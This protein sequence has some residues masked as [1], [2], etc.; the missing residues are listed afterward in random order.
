MLAAVLCQ[1]GRVQRLEDLGCA[2][3]LLASAGGESLFNCVFGRDA[4][5]MALDLP[6]DFP[7]VARSTLLELARLQG[8]V[9]NPRADEQ[10]G[11][12]LH[13]HRYAHDARA[14]ELGA[15]WDFPYY[16]AVDSTPQWIILLGACCNRY[17]D[18]ILREPLVDRLGR[19]ITLRD[20]LQ[21]ALAWLL[22]RLDD[23]H[24]YGF[25]WVKRSSP[26]GMLNQVWEDSF[27]AYHHAD[28]RLLD[29]EVPYAPVAP[30]GYT[31]DA[32]LAAA[33]LLDRS[34]GAPLAVDTDALRLR[35]ARLREKVLSDFWL[36]DLG[37]FAHALE[38]QPDGPIPARVVASSPGHLLANRLLDGADAA[39]MRDSLAATLRSDAMLAA[40]G[41]RTKSTGSPRFRAGA[42]HNGSTWPMDTG[43]IADGLRRHG[44]VAQADDL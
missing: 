3:P 41:V 33:T 9:E 44:Y 38:L 29:P 8:V 37:A 20:S 43:V 11:R 42:Y 39:P 6:E 18:T 36:A 34:P 30:Q 19:R 7:L 5:R 16:G 17:G 32:L 1:L 25:L 31:Y 28:G 22:T 23:P 27:D 2:G 40:A 14:A 21:A 10:P 35:A 24:G 13:E 12:I 15:H 4:I 26:T